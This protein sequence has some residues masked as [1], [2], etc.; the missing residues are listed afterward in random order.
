M[1]SEIRDLKAAAHALTELWSPRVVAELNGQY[2]KVA[3]VKGEF[4]WHDHADQDEMFLVLDGI[5]HIELRDRT[6]RLGPGQIFV[7]PRGVEHRPFA[8]ETCCIALF[9]PIDTRH[10]GTVETAL[11]R[12]IDEQRRGLA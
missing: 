2:L 3:K 11:T 7:V 5:F 10:T 12:S 9:E 1:E 4:V 8:P 6:V